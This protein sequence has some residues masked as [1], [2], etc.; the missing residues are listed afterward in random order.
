MITY[1]FAIPLIGHGLAH[2]S[3]VFAPWSRQALGFS[4]AAWLYSG[5]VTLS[6]TIGRGYSLVWL[7]ASA[8][9]ALSGAGLLFRQKFWIP[10]A[11]LGSLLSL[12]AILSWWKAVPPGA[13]FGAIFDLLTLA[14]LLSPLR[15]RIE[16]FLR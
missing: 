3:G 6:S 1:L 12:V 2:L 11:V 13:K 8:C 9:L 7:A 10:L 15:E 5:E 14:A 4:N 16:L